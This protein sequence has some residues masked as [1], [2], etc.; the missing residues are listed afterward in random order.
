MWE[1]AEKKPEQHKKPGHAKPQSNRRSCFIFKMWAV[2]CHC[3]Y[4]NEIRP[5]SGVGLAFRFQWQRQCTTPGYINMLRGFATYWPGR[6]YAN[7]MSVLK[8]LKSELLS[9]HDSLFATLKMRMKTNNVLKAVKQKSI[10][11]WRCS[12]TDLM[13]SQI[14]TR[15]LA[16]VRSTYNAARLSSLF[17][18]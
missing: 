5:E 9:T 18:V 10:T 8:P 1:R 12:R 3:M 17:D 16:G 4:R 14:P 2:R 7:P 15:T 11:V 6:N 13:I